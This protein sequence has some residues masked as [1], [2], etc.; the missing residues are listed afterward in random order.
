MTT[1]HGL[2]TT[3]YGLPTKIMATIN[4]NSRLR[5]QEFRKLGQPTSA[6]QRPVTRLG[7]RFT[8]VLTDA[9]AEIIRRK[10]LGIRLTADEEFHLKEI[11]Q[12]LLREWIPAPQVAI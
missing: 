8:M 2:R 11:C 3:D 5:R 4:L 7:R 6:L 12:T 9:Q 10:A 1:D